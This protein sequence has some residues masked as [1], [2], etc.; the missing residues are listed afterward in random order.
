M[1]AERLLGDRAIARAVCYRALALAWSPPS[2][3][4][5]PALREALEALPAAAEV[6]GPAAA[7][8]AH[9]VADALPRDADELERRYARAY[10]HTRSPDCP[11]YETSYSSR[12]LFQQTTQMADLAGFYRAFGVEVQGEPPDHLAVELEFCYLLSTKEAVARR[13]GDRESARICR[14]ALR[15]FYRDHLARWLP[16]VA[17]RT[18]A[19]VDDPAY[20][21][22]ADLLQQLVAAETRRLRLHDLP[23]WSPEP[24]PLP[25]PEDCDGC[26]VVDAPPAVRPSREE[27]GG[28]S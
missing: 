11:L 2:R 12:N 24:Q 26:P 13:H 9:R 23:A 25:E 28:P 27:E 17:Q 3:E 5:A 10:T 18:R 21:A 16:A 4:N 19:R 14:A 7:A 20:R 6:L 22:A 8:A 15:A 1:S